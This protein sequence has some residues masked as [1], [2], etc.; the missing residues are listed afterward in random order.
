M[1]NGI[2]LT[3]CRL[4]GDSK[5]ASLNATNHDTRTDTRYIVRTPSDLTCL[6]KLSREPGLAKG[7]PTLGESGGVITHHR[8]FFLVGKRVN[9]S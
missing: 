8:R 3:H 1:Y 7:V 4:I 9:F 6:C 5:R 2:Y